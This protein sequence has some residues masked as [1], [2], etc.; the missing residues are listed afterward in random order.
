[1]KQ[2]D[3]VFGSVHLFVCVA[4]DCGSYIVHYLNVP[5][6]HCAPTT[7]IVHHGAQGGPMS[8]RSRGSPQHFSFCSI[9][10]VENKHANQGS[11]CS[12]VP[13]YNLVV[14]NVALYQSGGAQDDFACLLSVFFF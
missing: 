6:L 3:N 1:M 12:S 4:M 9:F 14:H 7:C 11:Q 5:G 2:G 13:T 10:V 8:V